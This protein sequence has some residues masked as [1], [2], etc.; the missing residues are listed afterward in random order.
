MTRSIIHSLFVIVFICCVGCRTQHGNPSDVLSTVGFVSTALPSPANAAWTNI[1]EPLS[2]IVIHVTDKDSGRMFLGSLYS[3]KMLFKPA[4][5]LGD[6]L[7]PSQCGR[8]ITAF[9]CTEPCYV[10]VFLARKIDFKLRDVSEDP[11]ATNFVVRMKEELTRTET[12]VVFLHPPDDL[13]QKM[14]VIFH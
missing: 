1:S 5:F 8:F 10:P 2:I 14:D 7:S 6:R 3:D 4:Y 13:R 12:K 11:S 9:A